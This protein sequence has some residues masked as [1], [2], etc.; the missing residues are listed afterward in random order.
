MIQLSKFLAWV[1][2]RFD[3]GSIFLTIANFIMLVI[4]ISDKAVIY[5][6]LTAGHGQLVFTILAI[7]GGFS[8]ILILGEVLVR[9]HYFEH[10]VTENNNRNPIL[11]Y[12][13][14][15]VRSLKEKDGNI[16]KE[17]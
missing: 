3:L 2:F 11:N 17:Q 5:F 13:P 7:I 8:F 10:Y 16:H 14:N 9:M 12:I 4:M 6:N 15:E 1:K